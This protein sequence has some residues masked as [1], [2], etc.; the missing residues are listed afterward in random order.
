MPKL[1]CISISFQLFVLLLSSH[2]YLYNTRQ[3]KYAHVLF[4]TSALQTNLSFPF[5]PIAYSQIIC[6]RSNGILHKDI[7]KYW[8]GGGK[9]EREKRN[10]ILWFAEI[11]HIKDRIQYTWFFWYDRSHEPFLKSK[12][13]NVPFWIHSKGYTVVLCEREYKSSDYKKLRKKPC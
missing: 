4:T 1:L 3:T 8:E 11:K 7:L 6:C 10:R 12:Y 2:H 5:S 9:R 13:Y